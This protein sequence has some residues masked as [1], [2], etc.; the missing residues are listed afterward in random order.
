MIFLK[1][2]AEIKIMHRSG[3]IAAAAMSEI[4]KNIRPGVGVDHLDKIAEETIHKL[5][6]ESS[7][8]KVD[9]YKHSICITPNDW[10]VHGIPGDY[11]LREGEILTK[12][13]KSFWKGEEQP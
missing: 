10:V 5:G 7:F 4:A 6:A 8:K 3:Q 9:G 1:S 12:I 13:K 11:I 2:K